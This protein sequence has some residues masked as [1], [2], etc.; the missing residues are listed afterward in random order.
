MD[1]HRWQWRSAEATPLDAKPEWDAA[2]LLNDGL[3]A[4]SNR[5]EPPNP[6]TG[7]PEGEQAKAS[8]RQEQN[9]PDS[10]QPW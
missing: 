1:G 2:I 10:I 8:A 3:P 4:G 9:P 7:K 6:R 5:A